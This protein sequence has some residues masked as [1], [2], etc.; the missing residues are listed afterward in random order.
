MQTVPYHYSSTNPRHIL[1]KHLNSSS[2]N[3]NSWLFWGWERVT[4]S[5][6][7]F[8]VHFYVIMGLQ[9]FLYSRQ[10]TFS[11]LACSHSRPPAHHLM[12][13]FCR[14]KELRQRLEAHVSRHCH[15]P[16]FLSQHHAVDN[17]LRGENGNF[18]LT[19]FGAILAPLMLLLLITVFISSS[20]NSIMVLF[21]PSF[22]MNVSN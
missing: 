12:L 8:S 1:I 4:V 20:Q 5:S 21:L 6:R 19:K 18:Y 10:Q 9:R 15:C 11:Q 13:V 16:L 2:R 3:I 17:S 14:E 22:C 7:I